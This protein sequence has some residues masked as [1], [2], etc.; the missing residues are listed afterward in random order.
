MAVQVQNCQGDYYFTAQLY[1][2][3]YFVDGDHDGYGSQS[4]VQFC[5]PPGPGLVRNNLDW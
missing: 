2:N 1:F 5:A 3:G 4:V